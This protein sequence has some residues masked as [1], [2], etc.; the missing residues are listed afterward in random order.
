MHSL[1]NDINNSINSLKRAIEFNPQFIE[2]ALQDDDLINLR[3]N[4]KFKDF[5]NN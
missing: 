5:I 3:T 1:N 2:N 4:E